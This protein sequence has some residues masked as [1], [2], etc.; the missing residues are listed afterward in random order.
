[1]TELSKK[2]RVLRL[3]HLPRSAIAW[4]VVLA[5]G[6]PAALVAFVLGSA[7]REGA[8]AAPLLSSGLFVVVVSAIVTLWIARMTRR[9]AVTL[10]DDVLTVAAGIATKR[11]PLATL[12]ANG[13]RTVDLAAHPELKPLLRTWGIGLPGL[14]S[15]WFLLRNGGKAFCVLKRCEGVTVLRTDDGTWVLLSLE[16][17]SALRSALG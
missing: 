13:V 4:L 6:V 2:G 8:P 5:L 11:F 10:D 12:R 16:D 17:A 15:G 9:I 1:M 7:Y 3:A 14:A